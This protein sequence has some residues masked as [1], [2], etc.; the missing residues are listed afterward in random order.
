MKIQKLKNKRIKITGT[1]KE[2]FDIV[3]LEL[4][5]DKEQAESEARMWAKAEEIELKL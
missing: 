5:R 4:L 2:V 3:N 1:Y